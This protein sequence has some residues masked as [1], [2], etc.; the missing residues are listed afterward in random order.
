MCSYVGG[1]RG[2]WSQDG[3]G[4]RMQDMLL[5]SHQPSLGVPGWHDQQQLSH[6]EPVAPNK[7]DWQRSVLQPYAN[8]FM[9]HGNARGDDTTFFNSNSATN[10]LLSM[11]S[12]FAHNS[13]GQYAAQNQQNRWNAE[14][15]AYGSKRPNNGNNMNTSSL[16]GKLAYNSPKSAYPD[17]RATSQDYGVEDVRTMLNRPQQQ[18]YGDRSF[19]V[20]SAMSQPVY[21]LAGQSS[22]DNYE[23]SGSGLSLGPTGQ[24]SLRAPPSWSKYT[25]TDSAPSFVPRSSCVTGSGHDTASMAFPYGPRSGYAGGNS[26]GQDSFGGGLLDISNRKSEF[27]LP[28]TAA[29]PYGSGLQGQGNKAANI[30]RSSDH[31]GLLS[32]NAQRKVFN[33]GSLGSGESGHSSGSPLASYNQARNFPSTTGYRQSPYLNLE[34]PYVDTSVMM[35][36]KGLDSG[37]G[38]VAP[39]ELFPP[40]PAAPP[41]LQLGYSS[42]PSRFPLAYPLPL[43]NSYLQP[44][45]EAYDKPQL[46]DQLQ[47]HCMPLYL[48]LGDF[49]YDALPVYPMQPVFAGIKPVR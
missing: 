47:Y 36:Q 23:P 15:T 9:H 12:L 17:L 21:N 30:G 32:M 42:M 37:D 4:G 5:P 2:P 31:A 7:P 43:P 28:P 1:T 22:A 18:Q 38:D 40:P 33:H 44:A 13:A 46:P 11:D 6:Y 24:Q 48:G 39:L 19:A 35:G 29:S 14:L 25:L 27:V 26:M 20:N 49:P 41:S 16:A 10:S 34:Q 3:S 45:A 8:D